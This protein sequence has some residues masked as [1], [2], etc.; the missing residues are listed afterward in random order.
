MTEK[1]LE[2]IQMNNK[3]YWQEGLFY[4]HVQNH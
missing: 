3:Q 2:T 1:L 4:L